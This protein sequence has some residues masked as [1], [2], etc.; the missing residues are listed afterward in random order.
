VK[1]RNYNILLFDE[2]DEN[3]ND[4]LAQEICNNLRDIFKDKIILYITH[5]EKVKKLFSKKFLV[6]KGLITHQ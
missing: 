3:L 5:N 6:T 1:T 4:Q 2:I